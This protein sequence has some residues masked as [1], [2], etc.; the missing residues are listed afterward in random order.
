MKIEFRDGLLFSS[1][2]ISFRGS[3]KVI[4]NM[5]ID[6]GAAES[7]ISPDGTPSQAV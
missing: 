7:I 6:T 5:V 3:T 1:I 4:E 2:R